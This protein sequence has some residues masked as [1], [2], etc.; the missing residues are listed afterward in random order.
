MTEI[1]RLQAEVQ[2]LSDI[3]LL[4]AAFPELTP[5]LRVDNNGALTNSAGKVHLTNQESAKWIWYAAVADH[6]IPAGDDG[7]STEENLVTSCGGCNYT[8]MQY[9]LEAMGVTN[10]DDV[11]GNREYP[12]ES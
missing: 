9:T 11:A 6:V 1:D 8:K 10:P 12:G 7:S 2:R 5:N 3:P 4:V